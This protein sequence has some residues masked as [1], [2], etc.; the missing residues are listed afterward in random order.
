MWERVKSF[1]TYFIDIPEIVN[2][3]KWEKEIFKEILIKNI[4][5]LVKD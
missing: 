3:E 2:T 1:H 5:E 4:P